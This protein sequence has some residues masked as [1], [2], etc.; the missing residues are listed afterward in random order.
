MK[1]ARK[2]PTF[3]VIRYRH[4]LCEE[5]RIRCSLAIMKTD[6]L[7]TIDGRENAFWPRR[8]NC[9]SS[10]NLGVVNSI[11]Q[12]CG[13]LSFNIGNYLHTQKEGM[14]KETN[15]SINKTLFLAMTLNT[16]FP[17]HDLRHFSR[18]F[19]DHIA[20][21][22]LCK[23]LE[24]ITFSSLGMYVNLSKYSQESGQRSSATL[25]GLPNEIKVKQL[26]RHRSIYLSLFF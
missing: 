15:N 10:S 13:K 18:L 22:L 19:K 9:S 14:K 24:G 20:N 5:E 23:L 4:K 8:F 6:T 1:I 7:V 12:A 11:S 16:V 2:S 26:I 17:Y 25:V 3:Y 21:R